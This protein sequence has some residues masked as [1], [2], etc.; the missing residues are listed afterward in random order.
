ME[1]TKFSFCILFSIFWGFSTYLIF[2]EIS[3]FAPAPRLGQI[4][5]I[6][7]K[8]L[9]QALKKIK[10]LVNTKLFYDKTVYITIVP[11]MTMSLPISIFVTIRDKY[12]E[13]IFFGYVINF[14]LNTFLTICKFMAAA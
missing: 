9:K 6:H 12:E 8:P 10:K 13:M 14:H 4:C 3:I 1:K 2:I 5:L 11:V 7:S